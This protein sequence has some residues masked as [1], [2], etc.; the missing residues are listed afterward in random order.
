M[1]HQQYVKALEWNGNKKLKYTNE[2][3]QIISNSS[4][5]DIDIGGTYSCSEIY[6]LD[7]EML[8]QIGYFDNPIEKFDSEDLN[9]IRHFLWNDRKFER[10][11]EAW[12]EN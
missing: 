5:V 10:L 4:S 7:I 8:K 11:E 12:N 3:K 9:L 1:N 6:K 2:F